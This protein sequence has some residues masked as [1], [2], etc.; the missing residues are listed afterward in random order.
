MEPAE[1]ALF[2][3]SGATKPGI[4]PLPNFSGV[5]ELDFSIEYDIS[6]ATV[7]PAPGTTPMQKP[8]ID[9]RTKAMRDSIQSRIDGQKCFSLW[10]WMMPPL[11]PR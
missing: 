9:P 1:A 5:F 11:P 3:H 4:A 10:Y 8:K 2:A 6:D 7:A